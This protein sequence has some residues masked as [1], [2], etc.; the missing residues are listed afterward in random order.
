MKFFFGKGFFCLFLGLIC[1]DTNSWVSWACSILFFV[2]A[3][4][5]IILGVRY[6]NQEAILFREV[7]SSDGS[8]RT[9]DAKS[10]DVQQNQAKI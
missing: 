9:S 5:Y 2:A 8:G 6:R 7:C 3:I 10:V 4:F 1:F